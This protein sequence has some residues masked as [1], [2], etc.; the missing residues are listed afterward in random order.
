[1]FA[2]RVELNVIYAQRWIQFELQNSLS[3]AFAIHGKIYLHLANLYNRI[4]TNIFDM[5]KIIT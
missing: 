2:L 1:M 4:T 3:T 5:F